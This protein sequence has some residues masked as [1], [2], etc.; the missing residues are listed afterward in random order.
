MKLKQIR[1]IATQ[2]TNVC[3][4]FYVICYATYAQVWKDIEFEYWCRWLVKLILYQPYNEDYPIYILDYL[5]LG[6]CFL[7]LK[8]PILFRN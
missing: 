7:D 2:S 6:K 8:F 1:I 5:I 3:S 4:C